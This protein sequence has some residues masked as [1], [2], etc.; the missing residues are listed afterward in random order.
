MNNPDNLGS[1]LEDNVISWIGAIGIF[2]LGGIALF[3]FTRN[4]KTF[5]LL[6]LLL[7]FLLLVILLVDYYVQRG[8]YI[9]QGSTVRPAVDLLA[10]SMLAAS[11]ILGWI[12]Y[13]VWLADEETGFQFPLSFLAGEIGIVA[14]KVAEEIVKHPEIIKKT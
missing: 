7:A 13:E 6:T 2:L 8:K 11:I 14:E 4:G 12:I 3:N 9:E 5:S 10:A 1:I